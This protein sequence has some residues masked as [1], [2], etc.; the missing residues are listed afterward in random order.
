ME[1][2]Q[3]NGNSFEEKFSGGGK[4]EKDFTEASY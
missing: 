4:K 3:G 2:L 1:N